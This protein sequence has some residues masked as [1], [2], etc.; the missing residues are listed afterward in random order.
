MIWLCTLLYGPGGVYLFVHKA[1]LSGLGL[2]RL[3]AFELDQD[4][5]NG[6]RRRP[7]N[8]CHHLQAGEMFFPIH[9]RPYGGTNAL[10]STRS[11]KLLAN[12]GG[13]T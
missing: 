9:V 4:I 3:A 2:A 7:D 13:L 1:W 11:E 8:T 10:M 5:T 6:P 12:L